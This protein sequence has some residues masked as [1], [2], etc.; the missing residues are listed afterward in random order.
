MRE[1]IVLAGGL[2]TRLR[3]VVPNRPK[4][5]ALVAGRPF[6]E[7][8]LDSLSN[9][10]FQRVILALGFMATTISDHFGTCYNN[11]ELFYVVE[12]TPLGT[13]GATRLAM[14]QCRADHVFVFNGDTYLD[15]EVSDLDRH[16]AL[17]R[18]PIIVGRDVLDTSRY[19]QLLT[20][21][22]RV[23]GFTEKGMSGAGLINAGCYVFNQSQLDRFALGSSF[24]L[25]TDFLAS[26]VVDKQFDVYVTKGHFIDIGVPEDFERAQIELVGY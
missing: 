26:A 25:E 2:G 15:L 18:N 10:G 21:N 6:L 24:S 8:L 7:I 16:W 11:L 12:N 23:I 1:A 17:H 9:K 4:S 14:E 19:G 5:M 22:G 13:G 20:S 3:Q